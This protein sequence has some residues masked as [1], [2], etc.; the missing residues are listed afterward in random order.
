MLHPSRLASVSRSGT[1]GPDN[2]TVPVHLRRCC[3]SS[4][5]K[6]S[7]GISVGSR[8]RKRS[9]GISFGS[10]S[11]LGFAKAVILRLAMSRQIEQCVDASGLQLFD[12]AQLQVGADFADRVETIRL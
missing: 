11:R 2:L 10:R 3:G 8:N 7:F 12:A 1:P 6:G 5:R 4:G 9:I